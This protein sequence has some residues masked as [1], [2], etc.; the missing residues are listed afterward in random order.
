MR[1]QALEAA[2]ALGEEEAEAAAFLEWL[3]DDN[4]TFLGY[5]DADGTAGD[6][7]RPAGGGPSEGLSSA[8]RIP[9]EGERAV[10][11]PSSRLSR[12]RR[13]RRALL[14]RPVHAH[15]LPVEPDRDPDPAPPRRGGPR[16]GGVPAGQPQREG[17]ARDPRHLPARRAVPDLRGRALR[18]RDGDPPPRRAPAPAAVRAPRPVRAL[19]LAARVRAA[20]PLQHREQA[21]HRGDPAHRHRRE[22]ASTT[23]RGCPSRCWCGSTSWPTSRP[24]P[25]PTST[26]TRSR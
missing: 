17:A 13:R 25:P 3:A 24:A 9:H 10:H 1:G 20:R 22:R 8:G 14:P 15:G 12:L 7:A 2:A 5:R 19:L 4:F 16:E 26:P 23:R 18:G 11:G 6:P 21:P